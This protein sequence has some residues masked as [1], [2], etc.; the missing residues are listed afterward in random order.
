[1]NLQCG[2]PVH[3][4]DLIFG[5]YMPVPMAHAEPG[6]LQKFLQI[7]Q[8]SGMNFREVPSEIVSDTAFSELASSREACVTT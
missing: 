1:M 8:S 5:M 4:S 6:M 3:T 2:F 7:A